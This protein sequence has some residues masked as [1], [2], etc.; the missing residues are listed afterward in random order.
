MSKMDAACALCSEPAKAQ[1]TDH[2]NRIY[3]SCT[4][5]N[6]GDYEISKRAAREL[7]DNAERKRTLCEMV[8]RANQDGHIHEIF[9][10]SDGALQ[11]SAIKRD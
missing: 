4:N 1:A 9:I 10:A 5:R 6:C 2:G 8:L 11:A 3:F 7:G